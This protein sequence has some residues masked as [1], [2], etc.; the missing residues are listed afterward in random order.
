LIFSV[1]EA[2]DKQLMLAL[3]R[4]LKLPAEE[5][6]ADTLTE[7]DFWEIIALIDPETKWGLCSWTKLS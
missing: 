7:N 6:E 5:L 2:A 4:R 3:G 1:D